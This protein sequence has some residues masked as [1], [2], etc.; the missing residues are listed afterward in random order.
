MIRATAPAPSGGNQISRFGLSA[1]R[2]VISPNTMLSQCD[3]D[4]R[5]PGWEAADR[6]LHQCHCGP[7]LPLPRPS[8]PLVSCPRRPRWPPRT[9]SC[10][11][12]STGSPG[13]A[14]PSPRLVWP[15]RSQG[16]LWPAGGS[17]THRR[18]AS[19]H[20]A[21]GSPGENWGTGTRKL[22]NAP[23]PERGGRAIASQSKERK[24]SG[25]TPA[26]AVP[27]SRGGRTIQ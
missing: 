4:A 18:A 12:L 5:W 20:G 17:R 19:P 25:R 23:D 16:P 9:R 15:E 14:K 26:A 7:G 10:S 13:S 11:S 1:C 24:R 22:G 27:G 2:A 3:G 6:G 8:P 21:V